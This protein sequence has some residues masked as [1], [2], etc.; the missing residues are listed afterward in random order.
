MRGIEALIKEYCAR[1]LPHEPIWITILNRGFPKI[2]ARMDGTKSVQLEIEDHLRSSYEA[3]LSKGQSSDNAW[4]LAQDHFGDAALI[5]H[6]IYKA[7]T[8]TYKC[9]MVRFLAIIALITL[10]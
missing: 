7:R 6:E 3:Y 8:Q 10:P 4:K 5:S 1:F 2:A 9:L